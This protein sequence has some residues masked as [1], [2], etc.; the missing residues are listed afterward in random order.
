MYYLGTI[1]GTSGGNYNNQTGPSG[2]GTFTIPAGT[3]SIYLVPSASGL[4]FAL[5]NATGIT[6]F[7]NAGNGAFLAAPP[8]INAPN[9]I[10]GPYRVT[11]PNIVVGIWNAAGGAISVRIFSGPTA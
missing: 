10:S 8:L 7:M 6:A 1:T 9:P 2:I 11:G 5:S 4:S 3:R